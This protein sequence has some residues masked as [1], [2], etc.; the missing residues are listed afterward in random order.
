MQRKDWRKWW[1]GLRSCAFRT[2]GIAV[3]TQ[4]GSLLTT[5][6]VANFKIPGLSDIGMSWK[7]AL[8]SLVVQFAIHTG[9]AIATYVSENPDPPVTTEEFDTAMI[10]KKQEIIAAQKDLLGLAQEKENINK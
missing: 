1:D 7:T 10:G 9:K 5:N 6:G 3:A 2:G 8:V 4:L